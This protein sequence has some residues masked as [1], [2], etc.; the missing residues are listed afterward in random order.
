[1]NYE[2]VEALDRTAHDEFKDLSI[3]IANG[4][5]LR[6]SHGADQFDRTVTLVYFKFPQHIN[7]HASS[8]T[9]FRCSHVVP[10]TMTSIIFLRYR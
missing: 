1:M 4:I 10:S 5:Q 6:Y 2:H 7:R 8:Y 9:D 3:T